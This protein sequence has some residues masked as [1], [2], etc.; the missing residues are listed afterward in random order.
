M[1]AVQRADRPGGA[2]VVRLGVQGVVA[3][4]AEGLPDRV[5]RRAGRR[6][7]SPSPAT[8][9]N[10]SAAVRKFPDTG[11]ASASS[12]RALGPGEELVPGAEQRPPPVDPDA[13]LG[14]RGDQLAQRV[15]RPASR[16][17]REAAPWRASPAGRAPRP[18]AGRRR[19]AA[20]P[21]DAHPS[22][23]AGRT[24]RAARSKSRAPS[25]HIR[26][27]VEPAGILMPASCSQVARGR[28]RPPPGSA[29]SPSAG[30]VTSTDQRSVPGAAWRMGSDPPAPAVGVGQ[31]HSGG[32]RV[33][34]LTEHRG[35]DLEGFARRRLRGLPPTVDNG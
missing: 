10:R 29:S 12:D 21:G 30:S 26:S 4:L 5:D 25:S 11:A 2:R 8:A 33:V 27:D 7:R 35:A 13:V 20:P 23:P 19:P 24:D 14:A 9:G 1:A 6:R 3:S 31:H 28:P 22:R 34:P 17:S 18:A 32:H 15:R 16:P